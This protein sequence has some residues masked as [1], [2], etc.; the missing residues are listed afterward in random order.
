MSV[1]AAG[2][3]LPSNWTYNLNSSSVPSSVGSQNLGTIVSQS[4]SRWRSAS[5]DKVT[6][7][8]GP[9]TIVA[10]QSY[11]GKNI[12][13]W[14]RINGSAL[15]I[16]YVRYCTSSSL[17]VDIDTILNKKFPWKW[18]N[19]SS[20]AYTDSYDA[21]NILMHELGHSMGLDDEYVAANFQHATMYGYGS[22]G[23]AK[24]ITLEE[25]DASGVFSIYNP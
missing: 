17:A 8:E 11:D 4:L 9:Q 19:S 24:K 16:T 25:G 5:G 2:W 23:E 3:R 13:A 10:R 12:V 22:K 21:E 7:S 20:C 1:A 14:G 6:F 15:G 18:S